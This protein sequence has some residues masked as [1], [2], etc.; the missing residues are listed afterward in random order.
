MQISFE[1]TSSSIYVSIPENLFDSSVGKIINAKIFIQQWV[2]KT[3]INFKKSYF[4]Y[5][6]S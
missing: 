4:S 1:S 5:L 6:I 3:I 2:K